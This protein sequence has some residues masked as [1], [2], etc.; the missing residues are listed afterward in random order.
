M[1]SKFCC[2]CQEEKPLSE[3]YR[4]KTTRDGKSSR[5]K[6]CTLAA[7]EYSKANDPLTYQKYR[8]RL[9]K[10]YGLTEQQFTA[11]LKTQNFQCAI[12]Y[13]DITGVGSTVVD[14]SHLTGKTRGLLCVSCNLGLGKFK[15]S[16]DILKSAL[17]YLEQQ[18]E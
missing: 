16:I 6:S 11:M 17:V 14:H 3:F 13:A 5:C 18:G 1:P 12:C 10:K 8:A 9:L 15:D 4:E 7:V 2:V